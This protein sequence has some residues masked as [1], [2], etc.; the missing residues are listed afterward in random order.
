MQNAETY[1]QVK[2]PLFSCH[3]DFFYY[4]LALTACHLSSVELTS[5]PISFVHLHV[6][7]T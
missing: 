7:L 3:D 5:A 6:A 1:R 4:K 2:Y